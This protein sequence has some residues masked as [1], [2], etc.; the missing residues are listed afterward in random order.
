MRAGQ[1]WRGRRIAPA[2]EGPRNESNNKA[3]EPTSGRSTRYGSGRLIRVFRDIGH[4]FSSLYPSLA[5]L[6]LSRFA[7]RVGLVALRQ[8]FVCRCH[9]VGAW[10][11]LLLSNALPG[12]CSD[13]GGA[14]HNGRART[15]GT[16][17]L[18]GELTYQRFSCSGV[19][20]A[21]QP[22]NSP[23]CKGKSLRCL[24]KCR[25]SYIDTSPALSVRRDLTAALR[26][27]ARLPQRPSRSH[28]GCQTHQ[29]YYFA[30]LQSC[31]HCRRSPGARTRFKLIYLKRFGA[32][33]SLA[34]LAPANKFLAQ[35]N[36]T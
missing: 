28:L 1:L 34:S 17:E 9:G 3:H 16:S 35:M 8:R 4:I 10:T 29:T 36:K 7:P 31:P 30:H 23:A 5:V 19:M 26:Y 15:A 2:H 14:P 11:C 24:R 18:G 12:N 33:A 22:R 13:P 6:F 25:S 27:S 20:A 32:G 21:R